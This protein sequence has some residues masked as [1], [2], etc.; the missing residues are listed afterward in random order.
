MTHEPSSNEVSS[1]E[2][3]D[4]LEGRLDPGR[5]GAVEAALAEPGSAARAFAEWAQE[6]HLLSAEL[7]LVAPPP[8]LSQRLRHLYLLRSGRGRPA[9]RVVARLDVDSRHPDPLVAVRGPLLD[10]DAR[11]QLTFT[12]EAAD[13]VLDVAPPRPAGVTLRGQVLPR[14]PMPAAFQATAHGPSGSVSTIEGDAFGSFTLE[15]VPV[16]A[17]VVVLS[18]DELTI[19]LPLS[20]T[21]HVT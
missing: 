9:I 12:S 2:V 1:E 4:W 11:I 6:F 19:E 10:A 16:D 18:N 17:E 13:V 15:Q 5:A 14:R 8:V 7:P 21:G 20:S 3:L